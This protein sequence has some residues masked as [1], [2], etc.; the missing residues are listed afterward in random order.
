[1]AFIE[2]EEEEK[3]DTAEEQETITS[4]PVGGI[5]SAAAPVGAKPTTSAVKQ[6]SGRFTNIQKYIQ[7]NQP[8][9][10]RLAESAAAGVE[11]RAQEARQSA[12]EAQEGFEQESA[13]ERQRLSGAKEYASQTLS[14]AGQAPLTEEQLG[15]FTSLRKGEQ[16]QFNPAEERFAEAIS[17]AKQAKQLSE[18]ARTEAGR[19]E[20]IKQA[21]SKPTERYTKGAGKLDQL[22]LQASP[23]AS[24]Q[25][26]SRT[27]QATAGLTEEVAAQRE[28]NRVALQQLSGQSEEARAFIAGQ[29]PE[30][31]SAQETAIRGSRDTAI[32]ERQQHM[33]SLIEAFNS[34]EISAEQASQ[35][36]LSEGDILYGADLGQY[37]TPGKF[38]TLSEAV[39]PEQASRYQALRQ[40]SG[41]I[42]PSLLSGEIGGFD[43]TE[44]AGIGRFQSAIGAGKET[45]ERELAEAAPTPEEIHQRNIELQ[46]MV[47]R[48]RGSQTGA[49][50]GL[51]YTADLGPDFLRAAVQRGRAAET[52]RARGGGPSI[53]PATLTSDQLSQLEQYVTN[54]TNP[55]LA[56]AS[57]GRET[58]KLTSALD[59][60]RTIQEDAVAR[61][62]AELTE[63]FG[64]GKG[65]RVT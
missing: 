27:K 58:T 56:S 31:L 8:A 5:G 23:E 7:A 28:A 49:G 59:A 61:K 9:T 42:S 24:K 36:G 14:Q 44:V 60:Y 55:N 41:T 47:G 11:R 22:L 62:R 39:T 38:A 40:L 57:V 13:A 4:A 54:I 52:Q 30:V 16:Q 25:F 46:S 3:T 33:D 34:G 21:F 35:L 20:L 43:P 19:F 17:Q 64:I 26:L 29:L 65:I 63:R 10:A 53:D 45:Y 15:R 50:K 37:L 48:F 18:S 6:G 2:D 1:M 12:S 32:E 51:K